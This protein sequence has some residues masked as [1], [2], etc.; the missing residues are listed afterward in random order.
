MRYFPPFLFKGSHK[1]ALGLQGHR[2]SRT[3]EKV[4]E[5][6]LSMKEVVR[7]SRGSLLLQ[8]YLPNHISLSVNCLKYISKSFGFSLFNNSFSCH[9]IRLCAI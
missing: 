9:P 1:G 2:E 6:K 3:T 8:L 7:R 4:V 5:R